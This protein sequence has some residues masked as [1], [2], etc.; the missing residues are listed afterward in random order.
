MTVLG[1]HSASIFETACDAQCDLIITGDQAGRAQI[2]N[3]KGAAV[4]TPFAHAGV[5]VTAVALGSDDSA[6]VGWSDGTAELRV[7]SEAKRIVAGGANAYFDMATF[8]PD[9]K[10]L[11]LATN[12]EII[13]VWDVRTRKP[14]SVL[15]GAAG[16]IRTFEMN[17]DNARLLVHGDDGSARIFDVSLRA[18]GTRACRLAM[19]LGPPAELQA[20][21]TRHLSATS[22][23]ADAR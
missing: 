22:I 21:C 8:S 12:R 10:L 6:F 14:V 2:W 7:H 4:G 11:L 20:R 17:D 23:A 19:A 1:R 18:Q 13:G 9:G 3:V 5:A 15:Q 16:D